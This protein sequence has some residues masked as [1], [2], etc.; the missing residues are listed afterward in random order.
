MLCS[1]DI[2]I[3]DAKMQEIEDQV[4]NKG[5]GFKSGDM[6]GW[7]GGQVWLVPTAERIEEWKPIAVRDLQ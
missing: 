4:R 1:A 5:I 3:D 7:T 6:G 2:D